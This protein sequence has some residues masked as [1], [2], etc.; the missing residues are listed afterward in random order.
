[1]ARELEWV[2]IAFS[3]GIFQTQELNLDLLHCRQIL[4]YLSHKKLLRG[5]K[6]F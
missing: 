6:I 2:A 1:M 4:Y 3:R 5:N